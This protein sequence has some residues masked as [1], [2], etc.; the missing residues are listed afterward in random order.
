MEDLTGFKKSGYSTSLFILN[1]VLLCRPLLRSVG[2][3]NREETTGCPANIG[4]FGQII[5]TSN[6]LHHFL[7][8]KVEI[9]TN[10]EST[11][12]SFLITH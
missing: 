5:T 12:Y 10:S 1:L 4:Y 7:K 3:L 6:S 11:Y 8:Y 9:H 2:K